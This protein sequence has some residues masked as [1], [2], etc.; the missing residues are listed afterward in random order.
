MNTYVHIYIYIL[1]LKEQEQEQEQEQEEEQEKEEVVMEA[2]EPDEFI[3]QK[4]S[5]DDETPKPWPIEGLAHLNKHE[6]LGFFRTSEFGVLTKLIQQPKYMVRL[7][8][9]NMCLR[10]TSKF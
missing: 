2:Q 8:C 7:L 3:K 5:R 4:Y 6:S 1:F 9:M 10:I